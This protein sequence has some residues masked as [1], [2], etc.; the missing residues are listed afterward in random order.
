[1]LRHTDARNSEST[2]KHELALGIAH[3]GKVIVANL[4][5]RKHGGFCLL[6]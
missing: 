4:Q 6:L 2:S 1:M 5:L 3:W